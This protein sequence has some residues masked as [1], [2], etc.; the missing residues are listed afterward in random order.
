MSPSPPFFRLCSLKHH[1]LAPVHSYSSGLLFVTAVISCYFVRAVALE[2]LNDSVP[3]V[4]YQ[5]F[6]ISDVDIM[7]I[8]VA[9][10]AVRSSHENTSLLVGHYSKRTLGIRKVVNH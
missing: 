3:G 5:R 10:I 2:A 1:Y 4:T 8:T 6:C 9:K 7:F